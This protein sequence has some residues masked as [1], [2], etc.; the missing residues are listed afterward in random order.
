MTEPCFLAGTSRIFIHIPKNAGTSIVKQLGSCNPGHHITVRNIPREYRDLALAVVR[1]PFDRVIS[2]YE[3]CRTLDSYW[4]NKSN[5]PPLYDYCRCHSFEQFVEELCKGSFI[6]V[7]WHFKPQYF[8]VLD[9]NMKVACETVRF[10]DLNENLSKVLGKDISLSK[11]NSTK[12]D[13]LYTDYTRKLVYEYFISDFALFYPEERWFDIKLSKSVPDYRLGDILLRRGYR[14]QDSM[15]KVLTEDK[16]KNTI[17]YKHLFFGEPLS[18]IVQKSQYEKP[19]PDE[20]VIHIRAGDVV[21]HDWFLKK[22]YD[23]YI[24]NYNKITFVVCYTYCEYTEKQWWLYTDEK[25]KKNEDLLYE[26]LFNI[27]KKFPTKKFKIVSNT[28]ADKDFVYMSSSLHFIPDVGGFSEIIYNLVY[29]TKRIITTDWC[30]NSLDII[31]HVTDKPVNKNILVYS[32]FGTK[33]RAIKNFE[34]RI[35][36]TGEYWGEHTLTDPSADLVIGY[37]DAP[38][39]HLKLLN[40]E[41]LH[42]NL[43]GKMYTH[44]CE[45]WIL[46]KPKTKFCCFIVTNPNCKIRNYIYHKLSEYKHVDSLGKFMK[47]CNILDS[48]KNY[49]TQEYFDIISEYKFI[50]CCENK[51][52]DNYI[53]E[54]IYNAYRSG[55]VPIYWGAPNIT[56][57][58]NDKTFININEVNID[59]QIEYIKFIDNNCDE[60]SKLF[61][62]SPVLNPT[63]EDERV[64]D[65]VLNLKKEI[66]N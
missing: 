16:Y 17:L 38:P 43:I 31:D 36:Y 24:T 11:M 15:N 50:I 5:P 61:E 4:H 23:N 49:N 10:E 7:D 58:F 1:N 33:N 51:S 62:H 64:K 59:S 34:K 47:N 35:F 53:T 48:I 21:V 41:R 52:R 65:V 3:Y 54:K 9:E 29:N 45:N 46:R 20:L 55:T 30:A 6:N 25:Q 57:M 13:T 2:T 19:D 44:L 27:I 12:R 22:D 39:T 63:R 40:H 66:Y 32:V 18:T 60:Y 42:L 28:D 8:W 26:K 37:L 14:W 56:D